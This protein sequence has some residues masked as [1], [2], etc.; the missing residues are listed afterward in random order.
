[1][2]LKKLSN[3]ISKVD[4]I[5]TDLAHD[6]SSKEGKDFEINVTNSIIDKIQDKIV[7][8]ISV[9]ELND[10]VEYFPPI[11]KI[12]IFEDTCIGC[13]ECIPICPVNAIWLEMPSPIHIE[14]NC[15]FCGKCVSTCPVTAIELTEEFF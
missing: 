13:G 14:D 7:S 11:R 6:Y 8:D 1:M 15:V 4:S 5:L 2:I 12:K 9:V 3:D 10:L